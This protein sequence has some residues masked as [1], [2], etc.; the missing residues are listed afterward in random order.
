MAAPSLPHQKQSQRRSPS[1]SSGSGAGF[2]LLELLISLAL[3]SLIFST[4]ASMIVAHIRSTS[5]SELAAQVRNDSNRIDYFIQTEA[6]EAAS[7][8]T[9]VIANCPAVGGGAALFNFN[10]PVNTGRADDLTNVVRI[11][12]YTANGNLRRCGPPILA[13]GRLNYTGAPV[14]SI[15]STNTTVT[16]QTVANNAQ[17]GGAVLTNRQVPYRLVFNDLTVSGT[18]ANYQPPCEIARAKSYF[19]TEPV[20]PTPP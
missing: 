2:T 19:V 4:L 9:A 8:G 11:F 12:Y 20:I 7:I 3:G 15:V 16:L 14:D 10:V 5:V 1:P 13:N 17:C 6:A 18:A